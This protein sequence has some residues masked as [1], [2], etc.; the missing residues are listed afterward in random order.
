MVRSDD[1]DDLDTDDD[2]EDIT[3]RRD[4]KMIKHVQSL[5]QGKHDENYAERSL[6]RVINGG[7]T[8]MT[9][10]LNGHS[11][12]SSNHENMAMATAYDDRGYIRLDDFKNDPDE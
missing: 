12:Q 1:D 9:M 6:D 8:A 2:L 4:K 11:E 5:P 3:P 7:K 10:H